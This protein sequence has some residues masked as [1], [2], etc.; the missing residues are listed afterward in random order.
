M[1]N[2]IVNTPTKYPIY[3][4]CSNISNG[5]PSPFNIYIRF[6][7]VTLLAIINITTIIDNATFFPIF[8]I[9]IPLI[10]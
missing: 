4:N 5:V 2:D 10:H 3:P 9:G 6:S 8:P 1:P 7:P